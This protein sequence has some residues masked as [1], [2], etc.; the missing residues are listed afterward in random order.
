MAAPKEIKKEVKTDRPKMQFAFGRKNYT[1]LI[2]GI[3][4][5]IIGYYTLSGGGSPDPNQF[6]DELFSSRRMVLAPIILMLGYITVAVGIM[7]KPD[8][9]NSGEEQK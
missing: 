7:S 6:N 9:V 1:L 2:A 3:V 8:E 5:L 4:L